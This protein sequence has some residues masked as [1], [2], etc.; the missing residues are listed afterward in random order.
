[1]VDIG[2]KLV[3]QKVPRPALESATRW[4]LKKALPSPLSGP[5]MKLGQSVRG[6]LP[7]AQ[8]A[9]V[10]A[11]QDAGSFAHAPFCATTRPARKAKRIGEL[12]RELDELQPD[13]VPT[14]KNRAKAPAEWWPATLPAA[15]STASNSAVGSKSTCVRSAST[16]K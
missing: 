7:E 5:A 16:C 10:P 1:M 3:D 14:L 15:F 6:L 8:K 11:K 9:K 4:P 12:T 13:F 2:H